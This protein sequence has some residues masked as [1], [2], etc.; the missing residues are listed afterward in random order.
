[1]K[2]AGESITPALADPDWV[3]REIAAETHST[4]FNVRS[5]GKLKVASGVPKIGA[6]IAHSP[7][8][9]RKEAAAALGEIADPARQPFLESVVEDRDPKVRKNA[10]WALPASIGMPPY[11]H[12]KGALTHF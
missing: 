9:L 7:A 10:R 6:Y 12:P 3:A 5:L 11:R 1:M 8:N 4:N 2:P